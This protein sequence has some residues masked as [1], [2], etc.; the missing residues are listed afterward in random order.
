MS[1]L[2]AS[3]NEALRDVPDFPKPGILFKDITP[4]L[5]DP[6]LFERVVNAM[7]DGWGPVDKIIAMESRGFLFAPA[8]VARLGAGLV[9]ARKPGK[10]PYETISESYALEYGE[11]TLEV[12]TDAISPGDKV[13]VVDDVIATGGTA[14]AVVA[15]VERLGG[16]VVGVSVLNEL[17]FLDG[18]SKL[19]CPLRAVLTL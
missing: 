12:H 17:S 18:R 11:A 16:T 1:D 15:L 6:A 2:A 19:S 13:L 5:A 9:P 3:V 8:M 4:L 10:L 14:A 7:A